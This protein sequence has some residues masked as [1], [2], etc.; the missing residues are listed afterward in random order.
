MVYL[1]QVFCGA[2]LMGYS[3]YFFVQAGFSTENAFNM[4]IGLFAIGFVGTCSSWLVMQ[5]VNRRNIFLW[6]QIACFIIL[7]LVGS[8]SAGAG[9]Q[10]GAAWAIGALLLAF[11]FVYDI[12]VGPVCYSL[13]AE[14]PSAQTRAKSV[15]ISRNAYNL[16]GLIANTI[17]PR[18]LNPTAWNIG[19]KSG[20]VWAGPC[21]LYA[22]WTYFRLPDPTGRT[23]LEL[24]ALFEAKV[25]ARKFR[26]TRLELLNGAHH[27]Q[28]MAQTIS[29]DSEKTDEKAGG[30][31][32][33]NALNYTSS[34]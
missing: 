8:I 20:F 29:R 6:G 15:A 25:P 14:I 12:S 19:A 4:S 17:Q 33:A 28:R 3:T 16:G 32:G 11:T 2:P 22:L 24:D 31:G 18:M 7:I 27:Q 21:A 30:P 26:T 9:E 23:Y 1:T 34:A 13:V 10:A 5:K